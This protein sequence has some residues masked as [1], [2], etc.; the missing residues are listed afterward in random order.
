MEGIIVLAFAVAG[1]GIGLGTALLLAR[2][3]FPPSRLWCVVGTAVSCG[4]VAWRWASGGWPWWWLPTGC[5]VAV[6]A[7]PLVVT[8][9]RVRRLPDVLTLPAYP[10]AAVALGLAAAFGPGAG[11]AVRATVGAVVFGGAHFAIRAWSPG[12]LG[13]GDVKLSGALGAVLGAAGWAALPVAAVL[14]AFATAMLAAGAALCRWRG[15]RDGVPHGPGLVAAVCLVTAWP[16]LG[17]GT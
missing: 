14:A 7:V 8:D 1:A 11:L 12:S 5:V 16:A 10:L 6:L 2:A 17:M 13:A 15:W 4:F 9:L 3:G